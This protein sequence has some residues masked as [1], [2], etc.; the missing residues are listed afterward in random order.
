M[1]SAMRRPPSILIAAAGLFHHAR[2]RH[3][4]LLLRRLVGAE[5]HV[6]HDQRSL[7]AAHD[8]EPLQDHH[9]E[10]DRDGRFQP[11]HHHSERV[12][13][14]NQIAVTIEQARGMR[15]IGGETDDRLAALTSADVGRGQPL[16]FVLCRHRRT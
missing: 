12:A 11:V 13:D 15:M 4:G 14:Q 8:G 9:V 16:D 3:E 5:R 1:V 2:C 10:R 7:R 6:H